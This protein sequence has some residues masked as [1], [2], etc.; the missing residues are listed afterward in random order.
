VLTKFP[1]YIKI[2]PADVLASQSFNFSAELR[3]DLGWERMSGY[4][5]SWPMMADAAVKFRGKLQKTSAHPK[6]D[7]LG[8]IFTSFFRNPSRASAKQTDPQKGA[9]SCVAE[10]LRA[11]GLVDWRS[12]Y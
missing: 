2:W 4:R 5:E 7:F 12:P 10:R 3:P 1:N 8:S 11:Q 6:N 9:I